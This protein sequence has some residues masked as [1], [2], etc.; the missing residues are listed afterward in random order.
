V[1]DKNVVE[2]ILKAVDKA[3]KP[4]QEINKSLKKTF[5]PLTQFSNKMSALEKATGILQ[6]SKAFQEVGNKVGDLK[7]LIVG[8]GV[9]VVS[10]VGLIAGA[11]TFVSK[12][13]IESADALLLLSKE[14]GVSVEGLQRL[15]FIASQTGSSTEDLD[16]AV[17]KFTV[18]MGLARAGQGNLFAIMSKVNPEMLQ[19]MLHAKDTEGAFK[20][21]LGVIQRLPKAQ[22]Q[23]ALAQ[24]AFGRG[25]LSLVSTAKAGSAEYER[26]TKRIEQIGIVT[27]EQAMQANEAADAWQEFWTSLKQARDVIVMASLPA[28]RNLAKTFTQFL[29]DNKVAIQEFATELGERLPEI[30]DTL[31]LALKSIAAILAP[32]ISLLAFLGRHVRIL[33]V[34][35]GLLAEVFAF[36]LVF[37][38]A[39]VTKAVYALGVALAATPVGWIIILI[40]ILI[41]ALIALYVYWDEVVKIWKEAVLVIK[42]Y[43]Q[44]VQDA[45]EWTKKLPTKLM[46]KL[47][48]TTEEANV[49]GAKGAPVS[50]QKNYSSIQVSFDNLPKGARVSSRSSVDDYLD[51]TMG[52]AMQ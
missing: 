25:N 1:A 16:A 45:I 40:G 28:I 36:R 31:I 18:N 24:I 37:A 49:T 27:K 41:A 33:K 22:H 34:A 44:A 32:F 3:T 42:S 43:A 52:Y 39:A 10:T 9:R 17:K 26:L 15:R 38:I 23:A 11:L 7:N 8:T 29:I 50:Q 13:S 48:F 4:I 46:T 20:L 51:L 2:I 5:D 14:T 21:M 6:V 30:L 47:G 12:S 19:Q 35:L